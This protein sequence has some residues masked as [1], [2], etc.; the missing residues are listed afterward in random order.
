[1]VQRPMKTLAG[2]LLLALSALPAAA[3]VP[4]GERWYVVE[5]AGTPVGSVH[6]RWSEEGGLVRVATR[7]EMVLNRLGSKVEMKVG[8]ESRESGDGRLVDLDYDLHL[9]AQATSMHA[10]VEEGTVRL[11]TRAGEQSFERELPFEGELLGPEGLR[12]LS[13]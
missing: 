12:R 1:M 13:S 9:S 7:F 10:A 11:T 2:A 5:I 8:G 4:A 6:E 3:A